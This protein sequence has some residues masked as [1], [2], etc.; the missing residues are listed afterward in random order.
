EETIC[1][2]TSINFKVFQEK[3]K[4]CVDAI[5]MRQPTQKLS[6]RSQRNI[7]KPVQR[8]VL[9]PSQGNILKPS[10]ESDHKL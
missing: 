5:N 8:N 6:Q 10:Q 1:V 2:I 4:S 7:C 9:K 3:K